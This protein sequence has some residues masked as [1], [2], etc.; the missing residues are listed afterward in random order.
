MRTFLIALV[1]VIVGIVGGSYFLQSGPKQIDYYQSPVEVRDIVESVSATG[2]AEPLEVF[3]VQ[4]E[5]LGVVASIEKTYNDPVEEGD[6]LAKLSSDL[7]QVKVESAAADLMAARSAKE[8]AQAGVEAA[9]AAK[10]AA[11]A[12]LD[13]ARRMLE[14]IEKVEGGGIAPIAVN[15]QKDLIKKAEAGL[16]VADSQIRQAKAG[17][18]AAE[19]KEQAAKVGVKAAELE[20]KKTILTAPTTGTILNVNCR[21]GDTVG[22][23]KLNLSETS[24]AIF[25]I[26]TPLDKMQA[27]VRVNEVD[28]SRVKVGQKVKF[29]VDAYPDVE[30]DAKVEQIR[31]SANSERTAVAYDTVISFTNRHTPDAPKDGVSSVGAKA[32]SG[33]WMIRPRATCRA[34]ILIRQVDKVLAVP[35]DALLFSPP[36]NVAEIPAVELGQSLVW[37]ATDSGGLEHRVIQTGITDGFWTEV[38]AGTL[39]DGEQVVTG[40]PASEEGISMPTFGG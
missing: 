2:M 11:E 4:S 9:E 12:G 16:E 30:F 20:L 32:A 40:V 24:P 33:S 3:Y 25:E 14:R 8:T 27:I 23:P 1:A 26:A 13:A 39:K 5:V 37:V 35:N 29:T 34:N 38:V 18:S 19:S 21:V 22:R 17:L 36:P 28:Y 15:E 31:N 10:R 6:V 7:Q